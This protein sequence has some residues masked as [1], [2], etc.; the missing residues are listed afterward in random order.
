MDEKSH[1]LLTIKLLLGF[2]VA[3]MV[4]YILKLL[5]SLFIPLTVAMLLYFLFNNTVKKLTA[6]KLPTSLVLIFLLIFIFVLLYLFGLLVY[7]GASS[8]VSEFPEYSQRITQLVNSTLVRLKIPLKDVESFIAEIDWRRA[9]NSARIT[10]IVTSTLGPFTSFMGNLVLVLLYLLFMLGGRKELSARI[11]ATARINEIQKEKLIN[12]VNSIENKIQNYLRIKTLV[13]IA[14][15]VLGGIILYLGD[16]D[17]IIFS[18][19]LIFVL[20]YIPN[21]GSIAATIFPVT[22]GLIKFGLCPRVILVAGA[23]IAVQ[24]LMGNVIEPIWTG[25]SLRLSPILILISLIFWGWVWGII[26]MMLAVP[27]MSALKIICEQFGSLRTVALFMGSE[28]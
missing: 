4:V 9:L 21:F 1:D 7:T 2:I 28:E 17:F 8:F 11:R 3:V 14:T 27:M 20:N 26:G 22:L 15:A 12:T 6:L 19:L 24:F 13:S 18:A 23:L 25:R 16:F 5:S 10:A